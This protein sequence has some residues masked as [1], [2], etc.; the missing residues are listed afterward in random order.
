MP[1]RDSIIP[2]APRRPSP[3]QGPWKCY[4]HEEA[5]VVTFEVCR[6]GGRECARIST[7]THSVK[8]RGLKVLLHVHTGLWTLAAHGALD[9]FVPSKKK[10]SLKPGVIDML[11]KSIG[12]QRPRPHSRPAGGG[13]TLNAEEQKRNI[14]VLLFCEPSLTVL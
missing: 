13:K 10:T 7:T 6:H 8:S 9:A 14:C 5:V 11:P 4:N 3:P 1:R 12:A 2:V